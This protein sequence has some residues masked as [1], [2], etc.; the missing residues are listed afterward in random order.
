[1]VRV[2]LCFEI[3]VFQFSTIFS[4][5]LNRQLDRSGEV[6]VQL[7]GYNTYQIA[8]FAGLTSSC[9]LHAFLHKEC[10]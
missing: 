5:L 7:Q 2:V 4:S 6:Q 9:M 3:Q 8:K 1:M 10:M